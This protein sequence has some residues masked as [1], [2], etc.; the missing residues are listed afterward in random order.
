[1]TPKALAE[2]TRQATTAA[3]RNRAFGA[4]GTIKRKASETV[5]APRQE[6]KRPRVSSPP[7]PVERVR[8]APAPTVTTTTRAIKVPVSSAS[9]SAVAPASTGTTTRAIKLPVSSPSASAV[10]RKNGSVSSVEDGEIVDPHLKRAAIVEKDAN[11]KLSY[12]RPAAPTPLSESTVAK[13]S[14]ERPTPRPPEENSTPTAPSQL[15]GRTSTA[16]SKPAGL[17]APAPAPAQSDV[18][19][20]QPPLPAVPPPPRP[21]PGPA[22]VKKAPSLFIPNKRKASSVLLTPVALYRV[23]NLSILFSLRVQRPPGPLNQPPKR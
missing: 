7:R 16:T 1:L 10:S 4:F 6:A 9:A 22:P 13:A 23:T 21:P 20:R 19:A 3:G 5:A 14:Y 15:P 2:Q 11:G 8:A 18:D 17:P 12:S